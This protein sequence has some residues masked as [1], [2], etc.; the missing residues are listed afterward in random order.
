MLAAEPTR[1]YRMVVRAEKKEQTRQAII[2]AMKQAIKAQPYSA[3][4][5]AEVAAAAGVS[6][7]TLHQRFGSKEALFLEAIGQ[8]GPEMLALR[9]N[10]TPGDVQA[11]VAGLV[12]QYERY[13]DANWALL[14]LERDLPAVAAGRAQGRAGHRRW[15]EEVFAPGL[16]TTASS[17]GRAVDA[18]YAATD[19]GT[20]KLLRRDLGLSRARTAG[21][22]EVLVRGALATDSGSGG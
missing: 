9:G 6:A 13:G 1:R 19:V 4:K 7:Q 3:I 15:L 14:P 22:I 20:W 12:G 18:L 5:V 10:P 21:A 2:E 16:P 17:R 8:L 11:I